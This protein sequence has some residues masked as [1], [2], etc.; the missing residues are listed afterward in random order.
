MRSTSARA[1]STWDQLRDRP[2]N[3]RH[4]LPPRWAY[5]VAF[6]RESEQRPT[7]AGKAYV[8]AMPHHAGG[9]DR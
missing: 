6:D 7:D 4:L 5:L 9:G 8:E 1:S 3:P 2:A